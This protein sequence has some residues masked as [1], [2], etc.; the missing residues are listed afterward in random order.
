M[1]TPSQVAFLVLAQ[2]ND[3]LDAP[4]REL[5]QQT[6]AA[7]ATQTPKPGSTQRP[8][9]KRVATATTPSTNVKTAGKHLLE[10]T[11][12]LQHA[13]TKVATPAKQGTVRPNAK[14]NTVA[15]PTR[16]TG[17]HLLEATRELQQAV[18]ATKA[19]TKP[20]AAKTPQQAVP[21]S[22]TAA[23]TK[24]TSNVATGRHLLAALAFKPGAT[25]G[26]VASVK[27]ADSAS[28]CT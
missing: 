20:S 18:A 28:R 19:T 11:R 24:K 27:A 9:N 6:A 16:T 17:K 7:R 5:L 15:A 2:A 14:Q 21:K 3:I 8:N 23:S 10:A 4:S 26:K 13:G 22:T 12:E 1:T 25:P